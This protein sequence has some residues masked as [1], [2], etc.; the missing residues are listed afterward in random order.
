MNCFSPSEKVV[1]RVCGTAMHKAGTERLSTRDLNCTVGHIVDRVGGAGTARHAETVSVQVCS[2]EGLGWHAVKIGLEDN[3][4]TVHARL[5]RPQELVIDCCSRAAGMAVHSPAP[6]RNNQLGWRTAVGRPDLGPKGDAR[7]EDVAVGMHGQPARP[8]LAWHFLQLSKLPFVLLS[9]VFV[10]YDERKPG[11]YTYSD[12]GRSSNA[13]VTTDMG[14]VALAGLVQ[15]VKR[16]N[17]H[18]H[19]FSETLVGLGTVLE[20]L[21]VEASVLEGVQLLRIF[22]HRPTMTPDV[23]APE[24]VSYR[25]SEDRVSSG[26]A[27]M[28]PGVQRLAYSGGRSG[29][30]VERVYGKLASR[31]TGQLQM[32]HATSPIAV[33]HGAVFT[34]LEDVS[35][36]YYTG[37]DANQTPVVC[38]YTG[39]LISMPDAELDDRLMRMLPDTLVRL[40][41]TNLPIDHSLESFG[42]EG[43]PREVRFESLLSLVVTYEARTGNNRRMTP[44]QDASTWRLHFPRLKAMSVDC[45]W[46]ACPILNDVMLPS[47]M[48]TVVLGVTVGGLRSIESIVMPAA[49]RLA[50][51]VHESDYTA[52]NAAIAASRLVRSAAGSREVELSVDD[53]AVPVLPDGFQPHSLTRLAISAPTSVDVMLR[54]VQRMAGLVRL[55]IRRLEPGATQL[56]ISVPELGDPCTVGPLNAT[57]RDV[58]IELSDGEAPEA[59]IQALKHMVLGLPALESLSSM[60][61]HR[62]PIADFVSAYAEKYPHLT[63]IRLAL[64][65]WAV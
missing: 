1:V 11:G 31:Y 30:A 25:H 55:E 27:D 45:A 56:D 12:E 17:I 57:L 54:L 59:V 23:V 14:I 42:M 9:S 46:G 5:G 48:D 51:T 58:C 7:Y 20:V 61:V 52:R 21:E 16:L 22:V 8:P 38:R 44:R 6:H 40:R 43:G 10:S 29:A 50:V 37:V 39:L 41:L 32:L 24:T 18:L 60:S 15:A 4:K 36:D 62:K 26:L 64:C 53:P 13:R 2:A 35:I 3:V 33:P 47:H 28:L 63:G 34:Q 65:G 19:C 49:R